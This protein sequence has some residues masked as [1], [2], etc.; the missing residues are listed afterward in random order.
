MLVPLSYFAPARIDHHNVQLV[1]ALTMAGAL[2]RPLNST[3]PSIIAAASCA[4]MMAIGLETLPYIIVGLAVISISWVVGSSD[5]KP[6]ALFGTTFSG[7]TALFWMLQTNFQNQQPVCDMLSSTYVLPIIF[8]GLGLDL[9]TRVGKHYGFA[10]RLAL[11]AVVG[12]VA[13]A[14]FIYVNPTCL[15]GPMAQVPMD[16]QDRWLKTVAEAQPISSILLSAP[17]LAIER[18]CPPLLALLL[19]IVLAWKNPQQRYGLIVFVA[20][21]AAGFTVSVVQLRGSL[22]AHVFTIAIFALAIDLARKYYVG[23]QKSLPAIGAMALAFL[24]CQ[25]LFFVIAAS[26]VSVTP[27]LAIA[28]A[29]STASA[30]VAASLTTLDKECGGQD[31]RDGIAKLGNALIAAPV[32]YSAQVLEM[33]SA[34][35]IAGPYHRAGD[36]IFDALEL[37]EDGPLAERNVL[38]RRKPDYLVLC[39]TSDDTLDVVAKH[40]QSLSARLKNQQAMAWLKPLPKAGQLAIYA[41]LPDQ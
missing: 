31:V 11:L 23:N 15:G 29:S 34:S 30:A 8:G 18:Y 21:L 16:L 19:G 2:A 28:Q 6:V 26:F 13:L 27:T 4:V 32:F 10:V 38:L 37:F 14:V 7:L 3:W 12:V 25:S 39:L 36:A 22:F 20:L 35:V 17:S 41:V 24:T 9:A 5:A 1:L 40:P 33:G